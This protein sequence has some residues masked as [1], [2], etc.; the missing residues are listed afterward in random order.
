MAADDTR[1]NPFARVRNAEAQY[2]RQ[3]GPISKTIGR[4]IG[5][6]GPDVLIA[7]PGS[8][9]RLLHELSVYAQLLEPWGL[10][11]A[12]RMTADVERRNLRAWKAHSADMSRLLRREI[13]ETPTGGVFQNLVEAQAA[14]IKELPLEAGERIQKLTIEAM[15]DGSRAAEIAKEIMRSGEV[16]ASS[17]ATLART[18]V[19]TASTAL[20]E[21]RAVAVGSIGYIWRTSRDASVRKSHKDMEGRFVPWSLRPE[22][23][24][25]RV[26][27]GED[28]NCRCHPEPVLPTL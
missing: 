22:L 26:H 25:R 14:K 10:R 11:I 16:S 3:L 4:I 20:V 21:A 12:E 27:A 2:R 5:S 18:T 24:G 23:D 28:Y 7:N 6:Y 15:L 8:V 19:G 17:A 1:G 13:L 9:T